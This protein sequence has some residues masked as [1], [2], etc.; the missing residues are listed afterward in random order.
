MHPDAFRRL[1]WLLT[2]SA[3]FIS[4]GIHYQSPMLAA[5]AADLGATSAQIA[6]VPTLSFAGMFVGVLLLVPLGDRIDRR[7]LALAK[8]GL[9][10]ASQAAMAAA[11][12][13]E[14]LAAASFVTGLAGSLVQGMIA[15]V[16]AGAPPA[17]RGRAMGTLFT[18]LFVGILFARIVGGAMTSEF[19]WRSGYML[20]ALLLAGVFALFHARLP[21][22]RPTTQASYGELLRSAFRLLRISDIRRAAA[23]QFALGTCYG[24]FWAALAPMTN[25]E[26]GLTAAQIGLI[27]IPGAAGILVARPAGRWMDRSGILP[28]GGTA[29]AA[30]AMAWILLGFAGWSVAAVAVGAALLDCALRAALVSNQTLVNAA[31][32]DARARANTVFGAHVWGGN[33][34]GAFLGGSAYALTGWWGVCAVCLGACAFASCVHLRVRRSHRQRNAR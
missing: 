16:A 22:S 13:V 14:L 28:V 25:A 17:E 30:M 34:T 20:S 7:R 11:P 31:A 3:V 23:I 33:A 5:M 2:L 12:S 4:G 24:A 9:L 27:G 18:G 29:I 8:L 15:I 21:A 19:G 26:H 1:L 6:W 10:C 32:P